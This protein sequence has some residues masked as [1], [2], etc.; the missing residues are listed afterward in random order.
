MISLKN[1]WT[2]IDYINIEANKRKNNERVLNIQFSNI[3]NNSSSE[4]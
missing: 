3:K 2:P 1:N 4:D